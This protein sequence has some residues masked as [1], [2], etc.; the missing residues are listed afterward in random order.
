MPTPARGRCLLSN[1]MCRNG[2]LRC[3]NRRS[4]FNPC[5]L[6]GERLRFI[7][8][9]VGN[10]SDARSF[11]AADLLQG[12]VWSERLGKTHLVH[13][14]D[15][16]QSRRR[17]TG[18]FRLPQGVERTARLAASL[19]IEFCAVLADP[20]DR[21]TVVGQRANGGMGNLR[22]RAKL[23][24][25]WR[26]SLLPGLSR[27]PEVERDPPLDRLSALHATRAVFQ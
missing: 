8:T 19:G 9:C 4:C 21:T 2:V 13:A 25:G 14:A 5:S 3:S 26:P 12:Q 27:V 17:V 18:H 16:A 23:R 15:H 11:H 22:S 7:P 10:I 1:I 24:C 6:C 20:N